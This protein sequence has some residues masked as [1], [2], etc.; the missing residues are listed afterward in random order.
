MTLHCP[1]CGN[2]LDIKDKQWKRTSKIEVEADVTCPE[3]EHHI[4]VMDRSAYEQEGMTVIE[5]R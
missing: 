5:L 4:I 2:E 3:C 1:R